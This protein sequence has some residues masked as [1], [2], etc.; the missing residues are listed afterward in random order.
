LERQW[1]L[2]FPADE[3]IFAAY[4]VVESLQAGAATIVTAPSQRARQR[5]L[6]L[7]R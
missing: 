2:C 4:I 1:R 6:R 5:V 3:A 7:L